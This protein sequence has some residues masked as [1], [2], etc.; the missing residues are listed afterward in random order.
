MNSCH[1]CHTELV[2][3]A[4]FCH[5]CGRKV[6]FTFVIYEVKYD[7]D[8]KETSSLAP[9]IQKYFFEAF[10]NRIAE[11]HDSK[12]YPDYLNKFQQSEIGKKIDLRISQLAEEAYSIHA[13][14]G[15]QV[16][17]EIDDLLDKNFQ[18]IL[19]HFIILNAKDLNTVFLKE[20]ILSYLH[21]Q[22]GE[23]DLR[24][25]ILDYLDL[26]NEQESYYTDFIIMPSTKL[27]NASKAFLFPDK[28]EKIMLI[29][30][31]TV[32]GS[33]KEGF[34][35]TEKGIYWKAHFEKAPQVFYKSLTEIKREKDWITINGNYFNVTPSINLKMLKLLKKLKEVY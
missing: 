22:Q 8:F 33:C 19:D 30:D 5:N 16:A 6:V 2:K 35:M 29:M 14:Q 20:E 12:S 32:F 4:R 1:Y 9:S 25:M 3:N 18:Q 7:L 23:F 17:R 27:K 21:L 31:Q 15:P 34:A 10:Q 11:E 13:R 28:D 24:Q 26:E